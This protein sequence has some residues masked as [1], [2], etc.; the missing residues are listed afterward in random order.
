VSETSTRTFV[1]TQCGSSVTR[2][3]RLPSTWLSVGAD[4]RAG[5]RSECIEIPGALMTHCCNAAV[6]ET[7][8]AAKG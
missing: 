4:P 8:P 3:K 5:K 7:T 6:K 1:C 2:A